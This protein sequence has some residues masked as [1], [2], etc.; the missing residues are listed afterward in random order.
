MRFPFSNWSCTAA[1]ALTPFGPA[2]SGLY[3]DGDVFIAIIVFL[4]SMLIP[5]LKLLGLF[6][7][8]ISTQFK[9]SGLRVPRTWLYKF[10]EGIGRWAM[11]DVFVL[12]ILVSLVK[13]Q[14]IGHHSAGAGVVCVRWGCLC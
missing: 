1:R 14:G 13:L 7:L 6:A 8:V 9:W 4:A 12:A 2:C 10:I 5:F 3:E 11:L